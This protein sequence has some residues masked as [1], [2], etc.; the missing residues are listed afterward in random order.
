MLIGVIFASLFLINRPRKK[1]IKPD[2]IYNLKEAEEDAQF[3]FYKEDYKKHLYHSEEGVNVNS[4][5]QKQHINLRNKFQFR[6][7]NSFADGAISG[8][9]FERG[10]KNEA[11]D[12]QEID[13][14]PTNNNLFALSTVGHLFMG[15]LD[16]RSWQLL[17]DQINLNT[18]FLEHVKLENGDDR[19]LAIYRDGLDRKMLRFSDDYGQTW[20][21]PKGL[22]FYDHYGSPK[23][24]Y[25]MSD[26][27]IYYF[28]HTWDSNS[29]SASYELYQS[30]N[31][32]YTYSK[33][34]EIDNAD[35]AGSNVKISK[36]P[37]VDSL[38]I[39][40]LNNNTR[41]I[42][43]HKTEGVDINA[44]EAMTGSGFT[45]NRFHSTGRLGTNEIHYIYSNGKI[46]TSLNSKDWTEKGTAEM[47]GGGTMTP[48]GKGK[49]FLINPNNNELYSG[50]FQFN[51][52][53]L[54]NEL[55]WEEQYSYWWTYYDK[56]LSDKKDNMHVDITGIE[57]FEKVDKTPFFIVLNH[58]GVHV[59]YD[60]MITTENLG[61]ENLNC[62]TLYDHATASDGTIYFGAQDKGTFSNNTNNNLNQDL[63]ESTNQ[64]TGDGM[65]ALF[66][67]DGKSYFGF[68]QNGFMICKPD[69]NSNGGYYSWELPG[70]HIPG[71]INP[72]ENHP[73]PA[74]KKCYVAGGN[75]N[76][77]DGSY[78]IEMEVNF[79]ESGNSFEWLPKQFDYDF[80]ANSTT[81][82]G[83]IKTLTA[84]ESNHDRLYV[85][86]SDGSFFYSSNAGV[87]WT[88]SADDLPG[89]FYPWDIAV[90][91]TNADSLVICGS[92]WSNYGVQI[93][94]DG[95]QTFTALSN[96]SIYATFFDIVL[97]PDNK[98]LYAASSEGPMVYDFGQ[99]SWFSLITSNT[100]TVEYRSVEFIE[101]I[102]TV[103]FG[104]YGRGLWDFKLQEEVVTSRKASIASEI[105]VYPN[106]INNSFSV[107]AGFPILK[108]S[109]FNFK[110]QLIKTFNKSKNIEVANIPAGTYHLMIESS[111]GSY[112]KKLLKN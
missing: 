108:L 7:S 77:G 63:I 49:S 95:G 62:V 47:V 46:Y 28:V 26:G 57:Y 109:L 64:T 69:K 36:Y 18:E 34:F 84:C 5:R 60:D 31:S 45:S 48:W 41:T 65:R 56:S 33:V 12:I 30:D 94:G 53:S 11:G 22:N 110:G 103:R 4:I 83:I 6:S 54:G 71:W 24:V 91:K 1:I 55:L 92:G 27:T 105:Q 102:S 16:K 101:D 81:G 93:S 85:A 44:S 9:W 99:E 100:P 15:N 58:A 87:S 112:Y 17:S 52:T 37:K 68:L 74:L 106:P 88:K 73:N 43:G 3:K 89:G 32:G 20:T 59:S 51:K 8:E 38:F 79:D 61:L 82:K 19:L 78:L 14:D 75:I 35:N 40:D 72:V 10:P 97:T 21:I 67:N 86:T 42:I 96:N 29:W 25:E 80:R 50:G 70:N 66:F 23:A 107:K 90:S 39:F 98:F 13:Y 76:G 111:Q 2:S 104:T